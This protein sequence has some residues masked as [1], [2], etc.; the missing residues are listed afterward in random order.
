M[1]ACQAPQVPTACLPPPLPS[2]NHLVI[3]ASC[4]PAGMGGVAMV[5]EDAGCLA[6]SIPSPTRPGPIWHAWSPLHRWL[7]ASGEVL[8]AG[9]P[10]GAPR[11]AGQGT[12]GATGGFPSAGNGFQGTVSMTAPSHSGGSLICC[13]WCS[14][15]LPQPGACWAG[16]SRSRAREWTRVLTGAQ[17]CPQTWSVAG[18]VVRGQGWVSKL[19]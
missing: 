16:G 1:G 19:L 15:V 5:M 18:R 9:G 6:T 14:G 4:I 12:V 8:A 7:C 10:R 3:G 13:C 2:T 17:G 11:G